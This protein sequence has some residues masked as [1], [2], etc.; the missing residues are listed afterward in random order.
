[1]TN[2][3]L[4]GVLMYP[5]IAAFYQENKE[6]LDRL[7]SRDSLLGFYARMLVEMVQEGGGNDGSLSPK[8]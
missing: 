6:N 3:M 7:S 5:E 8:I 2:E 4:R 1:M